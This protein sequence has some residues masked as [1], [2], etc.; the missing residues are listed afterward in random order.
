MTV[1]LVDDSPTMR[2]I[3]GMS[4]KSQGFQLLEAENGQDA[5]NKLTGSDNID[6]FVVDINMPVMNGIEFVTQLRTNNNYVSSPVV[7]LTTEIDQQLKDQ[8]EKLSAIA[9][10]NK[11]LKK[12][13]LFNVIENKL[14]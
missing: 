13:E 4:L 5:L 8:G 1:M 2:K 9:W 14:S 7:F 10:L 11:P 3:T 6:L 12:E